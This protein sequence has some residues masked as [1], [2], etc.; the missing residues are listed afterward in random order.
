MHT[1]ASP[2]YLVTVT[3]TGILLALIHVSSWAGDLRFSS[4]ET[5]TTVIELYTSEG[6]SSCPPADTW[7]S[8]FTTDPELWTRIIPLAFHVDYWNYLGWTDR[9]SKAEY[10][11][12]QRQ[13]A[14][15][16][17]AGTVYTPGFFRNGRE[18]RGWFQRQPIPQVSQ[19]PAGRLTVVVSEESVTANFI[20]AR[21]LS[22][23]M[24]LNMAELGF[25]LEHAIKSGEN[26]GQKLRHDFVVTSLRQSK[27]LDPD[28]P[29]AGYHWH[30]KRQSEKDGNAPTQAMAF[31]VTT[32]NDPTPIQA[33]GGWLVQP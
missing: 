7:L 15:H 16:G 29:D 19:S 14:Q 3:L 2:N 25:G 20:P 10:S 9:L 18:W 27:S 4:G 5:Q 12:R 24:L 32:P 30:V 6:C 8:R 26:A 22:T 28:S 11:Q 33:T 23:P 17:Y 13:Y 1:T 21:Q 31:W